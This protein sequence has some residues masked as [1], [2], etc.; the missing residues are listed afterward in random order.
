MP[1]L[2]PVLGPEDLPLPERMAARLDGELVALGAGHHLVD[3]P[4]TAALRLAAALSGQPSRVIAELGTAAWVWGAVLL[5]PARLE[6]CV[7]LDARARPPGARRAGLREV[8][9]SKAEVRELGAG[10]VTTPVRTA[11]DLARARERFAVEDRAAVRGLARIGG[12]GLEECLDAL[13]SRRNL[14]DRRRAIAR[15]EEALG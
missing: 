4:P 13:R 14:P 2:P 15:L 3:E 11:V 6:L 5:P 8:I 9:L 1:Q 10:R 7:A 12:F